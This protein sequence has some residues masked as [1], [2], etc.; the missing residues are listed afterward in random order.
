MSVSNLCLKDDASVV[1]TVTHIAMCS[2]IRLYE[3]DVVHDESRAGCNS[4]LSLYFLCH[5]KVW[6]C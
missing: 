3:E 6:N 5:G 4:Y 1:C 2:V